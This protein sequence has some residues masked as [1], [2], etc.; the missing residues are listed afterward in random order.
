M[1]NFFGNQTSK[2]MLFYYYLCSQVLVCLNPYG[3]CGGGEG[4]VWLLW[5]SVSCVHFITTTEKADKGLDVK[6]AAQPSSSSSST[7]QHEQQNTKKAEEKQ[8]AAAVEPPKAKE[9]RRFVFSQCSEGIL[10]VTL[11][12]DA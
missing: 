1:A 4:Y 5:L 2:M 9:A 6:V 7:A 10:R 8:E 12:C 3:G 11:H